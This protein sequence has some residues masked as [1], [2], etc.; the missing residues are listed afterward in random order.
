MENLNV[1]LFS[2]FPEGPLVLHVGW[3]GVGEDGLGTRPSPQS[4]PGPWPG[5]DGPLQ[6]PREPPSPKCQSFFPSAE[7]IVCVRMQIPGGGR[8]VGPL[9]PVW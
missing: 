8:E 6:G 9:G 5:A 4:R 2:P 3:G 7:S 1:F